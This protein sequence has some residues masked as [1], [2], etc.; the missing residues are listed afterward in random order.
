[1]CL[2]VCVCE[3]EREREREGEKLCQFAVQQSL[4]QH[5]KSNITEKIKILPKKDKEISWIQG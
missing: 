3:R 5:C 2:C 4:T 1:M